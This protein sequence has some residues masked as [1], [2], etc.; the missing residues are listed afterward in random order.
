MD[1]GPDSPRGR[2]DSETT[3]GPDGGGGGLGSIGAVAVALLLITSTGAGAVA[4]GSGPASAQTGFSSGDVDLDVFVPDN[5]FTPGTTDELTLQVANDG[6]INDGSSPG[7]ADITTTARNVRVE[8]DEQ[9]APISIETGKRSIGSVTTEE[10][11]DVPIEIDVPEGAAEG[12]Y[13]IGVELEYR[14]TSRVFDRGGTQGDRSHTVT[15]EVDIEIDDAPRF[16]LSEVE[17]TAQIDDSGARRPRSRTSA[18][19]ARRT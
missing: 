16:D 14:H 3:T 18:A 19:S 5:T 15:R 11:R 8:V 2:T 10:P 13:E 12:T 4:L 6:G 17:T 9:R 7:A 1:D